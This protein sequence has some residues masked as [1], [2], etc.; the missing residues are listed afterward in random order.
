MKLDFRQVESLM[1]ALEQ[2]PKELP[3]RML[4]PAGQLIRDEAIM[5]APVG[6]ATTGGYVS[7]KTGSQ[8]PGTLRD[9]VYLAYSDRRSNDTATTYSVSWNGDAFWG[10]FMEFG[11]NIGVLTKSGGPY[12][13]VPVPGGGFASIKGLPHVGPDSRFVGASFLG[14]AY[15][16][17][18][19]E[20]M[21]LA[22][23]EGRRAAAELLGGKR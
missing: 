22:M 23:D 7:G 19:D 10:T 21:R 1:G 6:D 15:E 9:A 16:V 20:A 4:V 11:H 13:V 5:R 14:V 8:E 18:A 3:R 12:R 17:R 2:L